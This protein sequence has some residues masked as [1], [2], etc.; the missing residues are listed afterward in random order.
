MLSRHTG[1]GPGGTGRSWPTPGYPATFRCVAC[2]EPITVI[3][4][5]RGTVECPGCTITVSLPALPPWF[6]DRSG[7]P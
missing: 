7:R 1:S 6:S 5:P 3:Y 4:Q 2:E